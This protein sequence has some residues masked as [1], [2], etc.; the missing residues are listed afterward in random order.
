MG[1]LF[2]LIFIATLLLV[3]GGI[4]AFPMYLPTLKQ[5]AQQS[6]LCRRLMQAIFATFTLIVWLVG[7]AY[8]DAI[9]TNT[10]SSRVVERPFVAGSAQ[11][12]LLTRELW[13]QNIVIPSVRE[14]CYSH[15]TAVCNA[16]HNIDARLDMNANNEYII[17]LAHALTAMLGNIMM[18]NYILGDNR[19]KKVP[20][21]ITG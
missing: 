11:D 19:K 12:E 7:V 4:L 13:L 20:T 10:L 16:S 15:D 5:I 21:L 6:V 18:V 8:M 17:L 9:M 2:S 3:L 1:L 14:D